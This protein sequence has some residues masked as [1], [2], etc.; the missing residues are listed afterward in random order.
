MYQAIRSNNFQID[1]TNP[2]FIMENIG[3]GEYSQWK[4]LFEKI[5]TI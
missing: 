4:N 1:I 2:E 3:E 5:V